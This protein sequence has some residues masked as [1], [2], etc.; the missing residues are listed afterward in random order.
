MK[1]VNIVIST[2]HDDQVG[3]VNQLDGRIKSTKHWQ[4]SLL[5]LVVLPV[6]NRVNRDLFI[7]Y[8]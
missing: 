6:L 8:F 4:F 7:Y 5:K 3:W 2:E 1:Y